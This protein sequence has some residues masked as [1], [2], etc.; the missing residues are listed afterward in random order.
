T[1]TTTGTFRTIRFAP[2]STQLYRARVVQT[3]ACQGA[4]SR[5]ETVTVV[6]PKRSG[7]AG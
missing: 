1:S 5:R 3:A 6:K 7:R 4:Q 2:R